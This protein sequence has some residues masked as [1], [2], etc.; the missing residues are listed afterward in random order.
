MLINCNELYNKVFE[1][2][3]SKYV[4]YEI[5]WICNVYVYY[6][7]ISGKIEFFIVKEIGYDCV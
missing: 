7:E 1:L 5:E 3:D 2:V 4:E 6:N